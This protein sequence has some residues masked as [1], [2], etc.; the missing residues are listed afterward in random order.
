M[1]FENNPLKKATSELVAKC[2]YNPTTHSTS[3]YDFQKYYKTSI[4]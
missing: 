4:K 2:T 1:L 3:F